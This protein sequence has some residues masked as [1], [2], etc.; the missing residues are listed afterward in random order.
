MTVWP[1]QVPQL[2]DEQLRIRDDF[3]K[4]FHEVHG[5]KHGGI[6]RFNHTYV[7]ESARPGIRTLDI[8]AGLGEHLDYESAEGQD[9]VALEM[10]QEMADV[11]AGKHADVQTVVTDA[12]QGLPFDDQSFDRVIAI[13][14]LEHIPDLPKALDDIKRVLKP[15]GM[16]EVVIPCEGGRVYAVGRRF[17]SQRM[18]EKRYG[19]SYDWYIKSEHLST[20]REIVPELDAR[21]ERTRRAY[22]PLRVPSVDL[23]VC[24]G[25]SYRRGAE[26]PRTG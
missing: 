3:M 25:L 16:L 21:F 4:Y 8:G 22:W 14:V 10:R 23:N 18:F 12:E 2:T 26:R 6:V 24:L 11:I 9:Y 15:G 13:H 1:K 20:P 17:T 19:M 7:L 5:E